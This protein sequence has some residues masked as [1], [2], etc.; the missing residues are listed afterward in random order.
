MT[1]LGRVR[2]GAFQTEARAGTKLCGRE[3]GERRASCG[4]SG[5]RKGRGAGRVWNNKK[6]TDWGPDRPHQGGVLI[7]GTMRAAD[8]T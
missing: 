4:W 2:E 1:R 3:R 5:E 8:M 6:R 7:P